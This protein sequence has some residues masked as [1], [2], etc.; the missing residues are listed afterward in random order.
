MIRSGPV[1]ESGSVY[2]G[3]LSEEE[4][5]SGEIP[6]EHCLKELYISPGTVGN[7]ILG[8]TEK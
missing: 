4:V 8:V 6:G 5:T 3:N 1:V 2:G 7:R